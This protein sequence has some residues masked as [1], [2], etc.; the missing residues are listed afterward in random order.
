MKSFSGKKWKYFFG[1]LPLKEL[2]EKFGCKGDDWT[3]EAEGWKDVN[4]LPLQ[5]FQKLESGVSD[6]FESLGPKYWIFG[7][8]NGDEEGSCHIQFVKVK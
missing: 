6:L 8:E 2:K 1:T 5:L 7:F 4:Y 3:E